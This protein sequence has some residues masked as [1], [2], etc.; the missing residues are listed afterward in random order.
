MISSITAIQSLI[1]KVRSSLRTLAPALIS[2]PPQRD[3][4]QRVST[5]NRIF[6][7]VTLLSIL[8]ATTLSATTSRLSF[9]DL[10]YFLSWIKLY[11]SFAKYLPQAFLNYKRK[12]TVGWAIENILLDLTGGTL[13]L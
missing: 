6:L 9:L 2:P 4:T 5:Y 7:L 3:A 11:I 13:S 12:S 10:L 8:T 1:Y